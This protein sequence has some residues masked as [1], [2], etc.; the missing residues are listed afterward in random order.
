MGNSLLYKAEMDGIENNQRI[1]LDQT[2]LNKLKFVELK[3]KL[4]AEKESQKYNYLRFTL[5]EWWCQSFLVGIKK[6]I[7]GSRDSNGSLNGLD[8]L[9][10]EDIPKKARVSDFI[11]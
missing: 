7:I 8:D 1:D 11:D 9:T 6:I 2:D 4:R 5:R 10:V 3:V